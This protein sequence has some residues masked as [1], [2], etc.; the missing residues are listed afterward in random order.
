[1]GCAVLAGVHLAA[2][3]EHPRAAVRP[4]NW[5]YG[6]IPQK[7]TVSHTFY[8]YNTGSAPLSV[9]KIDPGC[10]CTS[11]SEVERP[12]TP[13]DSTALIVTFQSGRYRKG[14]KKAAK[15]HTDDPNEPIQRLR[16]EAYVVKRGED[17][18]DIRIAPQSLV[19]RLDETTGDLEADSVT[20]ANNGEDSL[21]VWILHVSEEIGDLIDI[22]EMLAPGQEAAGLLK[23]V[24]A[25]KIDKGRALSATLA[26]AGR[27][28]TI[29][30]IP[31]ETEK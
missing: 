30:T 11:V 2:A 12:I 15:L 21:T 1:L 9:T 17:V 24:S 6:F 25:P 26:F 3:Q 23:P 22:P 29:I 10:A 7:A 19:C 28:T 16:Y 18:G 31:I 5:D 20:I 13:G 27:D 4:S 14:V 8:L